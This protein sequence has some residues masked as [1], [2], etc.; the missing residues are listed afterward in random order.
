MHKWIGATLQL[1]AAGLFV[2]AGAAG[3]P[4]LVPAAAVGLAGLWAWSRDENRRPR[5]PAPEPAPRPEP[6]PEL[7]ARVEQLQRTLDSM[8]DEVGRLTEDRDFFQRLYSGAK[9]ESQRPT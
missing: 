2:G 3:F 8:Q 9:S 6:T 5:P 1:I 7:L 4:L